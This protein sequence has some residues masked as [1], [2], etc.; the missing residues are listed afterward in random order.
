MSP[1][2][3][4]AK[5][6]ATGGN[7]QPGPDRGAGFGLQGGDGLVENGTERRVLGRLLPGGGEGQELVSGVIGEL[8][9][10]L[11]QVVRIGGRVSRENGFDELGEL[12]VAFE[13]GHF[14]EVL[15]RLFHRD[16]ARAGTAPELALR[17]L[18]L[19]PLALAEG[20]LLGGILE[21]R[22]GISHMLHPLTAKAT[23]GAGDLP[24]RCAR[25]AR[26]DPAPER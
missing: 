8:P 21:L 23:L 10:E 24:G 20:E 17:E 6:C 15:P 4:P 22:G 9:G 2:S 11:P 5:P 18:L 19:D 14:A 16:G 3:R 26:A 13:V 7:V 25:R 12:P 1:I